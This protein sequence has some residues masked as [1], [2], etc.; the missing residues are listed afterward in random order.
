MHSQ[1]LIVALSEDLQHLLSTVP[2]LVHS[3]R[4]LAGVLYALD[5]YYQ[6]D[7]RCPELAEK[8][9]VE[10]TKKIL[11]CIKKGHVPAKN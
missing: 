9:Y 7:D 10:R 2:E 1:G 8:E 3:W 6:L 4:F 11:S 5:Q